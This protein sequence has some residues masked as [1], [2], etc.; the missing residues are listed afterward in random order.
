MACFIINNLAQLGEP[1]LN[2]FKKYERVLTLVS[3]NDEGLSPI[4]SNILFAL[5]G[6]G[7]DNSNNRENMAITNMR[8]NIRNEMEEEVSNS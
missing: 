4:T 1:A 7:D 5:S 8:I 3:F 6:R 2:I